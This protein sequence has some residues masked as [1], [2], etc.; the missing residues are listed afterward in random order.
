MKKKLW[1]GDSHSK[2]PD[3]AQSKENT[4]VFTSTGEFIC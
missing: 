2:N 3:L 4:V 1:M